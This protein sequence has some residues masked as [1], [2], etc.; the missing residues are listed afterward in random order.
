MARRGASRFITPAVFETRAGGADQFGNPDVQ[1]QAYARRKVMIDESPRSELLSGGI[2]QSHTRATLRCRS[3]VLMVALP[4]DARVLIK[5]RYWS[6][7]S[8]AEG[9]RHET[10]ERNT[11]VMTVDKGSAT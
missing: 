2:L 6:I 4:T 1:W 9:D 8:V 3:D 10:A 11:L 5:G 7:V